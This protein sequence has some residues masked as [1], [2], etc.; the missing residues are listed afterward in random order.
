MIAIDTNVLVRFLVEDDED[1]S[2]RAASFIANAISN[3]ETIFICDTVLVE[4][5]WVLSRS[6]R[7]TR[8]EIASTVQK[9]LAARNVAFSSSDRIAATLRAYRKGSAGFADYLIREQAREFDCREIATFDKKLLQEP[10][11]IEP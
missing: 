7:S 8:E 1:Q 4:T 3:E 2:A 9:L 10:D 11:F 5:V 6:Y